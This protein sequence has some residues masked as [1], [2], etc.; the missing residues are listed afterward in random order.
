MKPFCEERWRLEASIYLV[1]IILMLGYALYIYFNKEG[2]RL[3]YEIVDKNYEQGSESTQTAPKHV[4]DLKNAKVTNVNLMSRVVYIQLESVANIKGI[5]KGSSSST[6]VDL[7]SGIVIHEQGYVL[8]NR[9]IIK[10][11]KDINVTLLNRVKGPETYKAVI[12]KI[13]DLYDLA[14]LKIASRHRFVPSY[15]KNNAVEQSG[16]KVFALGNPYGRSLVNNPGTIVYSNR[17]LL[18]NNRNI[19]SLMIVDNKIN[20]KNSGGAAD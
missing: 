18:V 2:T 1:L 16:E 12:L 17:T 6:P 15:M 5:P 13:D 9:H 20:W 4:N 8:T 11:S 14:L 10:R 19:P 7:G 3:F